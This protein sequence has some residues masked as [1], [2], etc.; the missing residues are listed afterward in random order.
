MRKFKSLK[1]P[2]ST[3]DVESSEAYSYLYKEVI[4]EENR[5]I[6]TSIFGILI[7]NLQLLGFD[8]HYFN[9]TEKV[10][11]YHDYNRAML[12]HQINVIS[13]NKIDSIIK[14][15]K[16][17]MYISILSPILMIRILNL[18]DYNDLQSFLSIID[19]ILISEDEILIYNYIKILSLIMESFDGEN[20]SYFNLVAGNYSYVFRNC[21]N[22]PN[23]DPDDANYFFELADFYERGLGPPEEKPK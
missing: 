7:A 8:S 14:R 11:K 13:I 5:E 12:S 21:A 17:L 1:Q 3:K 20:S 22:F 16:F 9:F 23:C 18:K 6:S 19:S 4:S 15:E 10:L 2:A